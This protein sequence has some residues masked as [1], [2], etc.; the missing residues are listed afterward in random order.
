MKPFGIFALDPVYFQKQ[1]ITLQLTLEQLAEKVAKES[2][3]PTLIICDRGMLDDKAY[4][5]KQE[6]QT[7]LKHFSVKEFDWMNRY[8]LVF[9]LR[10]AALGK[11]K[12]Y[13][14]DNNNARTETPQEARE[15]DKKTLEAWLGHEKLKIIGNE[16]SFEE[17][18]NQV[19]KEIYGELSK[20]YPIQIQRKYL[21]EQ[22][23][24]E[25]IEKVTLVK[26]QLEQYVIE[27]DDIEY[28]YRKTGKEKEEKYTLITKIDTPINNERITTQR[29][30]SAE[31]YCL[32]LPKEQ[33]PMK[34]TRY[35]F[36]SDNTYFRLDVFSNNLQILEVETTSPSDEIKIP[37][38]LKIS[39]EVTKN[40]DYRNS[41]LYKNSSFSPTKN[42]T[43]RKEK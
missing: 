37:N 15:K 25:K 17:K 33:L 19:I 36:E 10:T 39:K 18:I 5:T 40:L 9:H 12:F 42:K 38:F 34:K 24:I 32:N 30:I 22:V 43:L 26:L 3:Y 28:I 1:V 8:D 23:D 35:C 7:L 21:V 6:W 11:E 31:E 13:T 41:S 16:N 20:P 29:N 4:V 14:L 27:S 2:K